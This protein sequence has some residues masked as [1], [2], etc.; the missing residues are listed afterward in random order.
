M[1]SHELPSF[2]KLFE[3]YFKH[4]NVYPESILARIYGLYSVQMEDQEP[5]Y[6]ILMGNS[7]KCDND[8]IKKIYDLK[9]SISKREVF[10][11]L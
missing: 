11:G 3:A 4:I 7:K 8:F 2:Q 5:V 9:G 6:L 1:F 10:K